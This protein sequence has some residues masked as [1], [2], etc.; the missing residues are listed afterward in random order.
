MSAY[1]DVVQLLGDRILRLPATRPARVG[2]DGYSAAG[3]TSLGDALAEALAPSGRELLCARLDDFKRPWSERHRYERESG[4]GYYRNAYDYP[5]IRSHLLEPLGPHGDRHYRLGSIHPAT[6]VPF[7]SEK[8]TAA[9]SAILIADGVFLFRPELDAL[10]DLRIFLT[11]DAETSLR[12][13]A[14]RDLPWT[15]ALSEAERLYRTRYIP[16]EQLYTAEVDPLRRAEIVIDMSDLAAPRV[17][18]G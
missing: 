12:R 7:S 13:G 4:E 3:K 6:G 15:G 18:R 1:D 5:L 14:A 11:I 16:S 8:A 2:I 9:D 10:W 17:V